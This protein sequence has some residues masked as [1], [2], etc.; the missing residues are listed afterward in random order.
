MTAALSRPQVD[1]LRCVRAR[2][3]S[4]AD[5]D[6][7]DG[8]LRRTFQSLFKLGLLGWHAVYQGRVVLTEAGQQALIAATEIEHAEKAIFGEMD[9][10]RLKEIQV[11]KSAAKRKLE[12]LLRKA[13]P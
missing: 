2:Q 5:V 13:K 12:D 8:N 11:A 10:R 4:A 6:G 7:G 3:L 9:L 1:A